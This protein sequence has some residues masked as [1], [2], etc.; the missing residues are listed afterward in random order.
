MGKVVNKITF[1]T[2]W[3]GDLLKSQ[4]KVVVHVDKLVKFLVRQAVATFVCSKAKVLQL[5]SHPLDDTLDDPLAI[6]FPSTR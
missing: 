2:T 5:R 6:N 4:A 1:I 3:G